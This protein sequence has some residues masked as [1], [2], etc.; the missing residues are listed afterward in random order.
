MLQE[1]VFLLSDLERT[2]SRLSLHEILRQQGIPLAT[3]YE[4]IVLEGGVVRRYVI[5]P[6]RAARDV[7]TQP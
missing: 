7:C 3:P 1:R 5:P 6:R 2:Q 4:E